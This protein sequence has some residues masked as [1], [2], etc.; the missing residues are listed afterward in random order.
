MEQ[1]CAPAY[2]ER[3]PLFSNERGLPFTYAVMHGALRKLLAA[4]YGPLL[5]SAFTWHSIRIGLACALHAAGCPDPVIQLLCRW[6]SESSLRVYRQTGIEKSVFWTD[7]AQH[8]RFE[9]ARVNNIPALD[10]DMDNDSHSSALLAEPPTPRASQRDV[11]PST[12][13]INLPVPGG[14]VLTTTDDPNRLV[15]RTVGIFN[16]FWPGYERD[17]GRTPCLVVARCAREFRHPDHERCLTYLIQYGG[18]YYPIKHAALLACL[19]TKAR[20][21]LPCQSTCP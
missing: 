16:N 9:A 18:F 10:R 7:K 17:K 3:T 15:S 5:A 2:R 20:Q 12:P 21:E 19:S 8:T 14:K 4:L 6:A 13:L 11:A 1:P